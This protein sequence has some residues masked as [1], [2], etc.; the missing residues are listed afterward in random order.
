[1]YCTDWVVCAVAGEWYW[2]KQGLGVQNTLPSRQNLSLFYCAMAL[3]DSGCVSCRVLS[4]GVWFSLLLGFRAWLYFPV[5]CM[6]QEVCELIQCWLGPRL[7]LQG[8]SPH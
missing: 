4:S 2:S 8:F 5:L 3:E 1:M 6:H 7:T